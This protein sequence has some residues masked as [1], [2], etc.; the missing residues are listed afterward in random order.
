MLKLLKYELKKRKTILLISIIL[1]AAAEYFAIHQIMKGSG[2]A[3]FG[4][5]INVL[6]FIGVI[7]IVF[8]DVVVQYYNDF[9]KSQGTLLFLT[10]N[11]GYKIVSSKMIFGALELLTGIAVTVLFAWLTNAV[12]LSKGFEGIGPTLNTIRELLGASVGEANIWW[13]FGG[14]LFLIFLQY[15]ASQSIAVTSI[16]LGRTILSK[17][18]YNWFW[19]VLFFFVVSIVV[20]TVNGTLIILL[21]YEDGLFANS[22]TFGSET[23]VNIN[24][25]KYLI[26]GG[27]EYIVWIGLSFFV[28]GLLLNKKVDI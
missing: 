28:S 16:T 23:A 26:A 15:F 3:Q 8:L 21:G 22:I 14:F 6:M 10:P 17:N 9:K 4:A 12:A 20:Q 18:N 25:S 7:L 5:I 24:I 1:L 11:S 13:V 2:H 19:A 27:I